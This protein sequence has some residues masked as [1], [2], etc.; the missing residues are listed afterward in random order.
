MK[1]LFLVCLTLLLCMSCM[2]VLAEETEC[3]QHTASCS[4]PTTCTVCGA[5][6]ITPD[7]VVHAANSEWLWYADADGH[8]QYWSCCNQKIDELS[9]HGAFCN[10]DPTICETCGATGLENVYI[11]HV[12]EQGYRNDGDT[13]IMAWFCCGETVGEAQTHF[14]SCSDDKAD[15]CKACGA[16]GIEMMITHPGDATADWQSD[17]DTHSLRYNC[18]GYAIIEGEG[19]VAYCTE[20]N[21]C[22]TCGAV[23]EGYEIIHSGNQEW[24]HDDTTHW[25]EW[26]CC[27]TISS[28]VGPHN[29]PCTA[30]NVCMWC[31]AENVEI[32]LTHSEQSDI[33]SDEN[34]HWYGC[35]DCAEPFGDKIAHYVI[36]ANTGDR[37]K[38]QECSAPV[39]PSTVSVQHVELSD[40]EWEYD[41]TAHWRQECVCGECMVYEDHYAS[42]LAPEAGCE[43]CGYTG[44]ISVG[45]EWGE[46]TYIDEQYCGTACTRCGE[47][48]LIEHASFS[49]LS[50][51][52]EFCGS[53]FNNTDPNHSWE[54]REYDETGCWNVCLECGEEVNK[55]NHW[56][57]CA[58]PNTCANCG[59]VSP[60]ATQYDHAWTEV[61]E[62]DNPDYHYKHCTTCGGE[63]GI[64]SHTVSCANPGVC[65]GCGATGI[66][67][68]EI[69][70]GNVTWEHNATKHWGVC[71]TC[72]G[73]Q[74]EGPHW[75][76]CSK[77][78]LCQDCGATG[79]TID[80][81]IL[82]HFDVDWNNYEHDAT[83][84]W[85]TC[86]TCN[87]KAFY[88]EHA[89]N[90][91]SAG[92]C[93]DCGY[94]GDFDVQHPALKAGW[95]S[96]ENNH[97]KICAVCND[98]VNK[99]AHEDENRDDKCDICKAQLVHKHYWG[100]PVIV[101]ATCT[102]DGSKTTTC[103]TCGEKTVETIASTGH[104]WGEP[105]IVDATCTADGSKTTTC[106]TCG[107]KTMET[108]A[109]TGHS[110]GEPVIVK[111]TCTADGSKTT[112]CDTCGEKAM[113]TIASTGHAWGEPVI[114]DATC[115]ADGSKTIACANCDEKAMET[116]ASTGHAW[117]EPVIVKATCTADGSKTTTCD[118]CG[119]KTMETI[120]STGHAWSEPVIVDATC[121]AD[122]S[123][124]ITCA[125]CGEKTVEVIKSTG[126]AWGEPV[127]VKATCT[128]DG[129]KTI[130]CATCDEETVE[131]IRSR[132]GHNW[133]ITENK[134]ATCT[135][136]G[137]I[138]KVCSVCNV[139]T[140]IVPAATGHAWGA[141]VTVP[142]T[143]TADGNTTTTCANCGEKIVENI[144]AKGHVWGEPVTIPATCTADGS[145]TTT[146]ATCGEKTVEVIASTGHAW[147]EPVTIPATC[148]AN[149]S[150]T[151]T[152]TTCGE[153]TVEVIASTGHAYGLVYTTQG[154]GTHAKTCSVCGAIQSA[155]CSLTTTNMGSM[156]CSACATCGYTVYTFNEVAEEKPAEP[157]KTETTQAAADAN[158]NASAEKVEESA[159][160]VTE[161]KAETVVKRVENVSFELVEPVVEETKENAADENVAAETVEPDDS[162][163]AVVEAETDETEPEAPADQSEV[164][165]VVHETKVEMK[166]ELPD[167]VTAEVKKVLAVSLLKEGNAIQPAATVKLS[168]PVVEEE[169]TGLKL[170]LMTDSGEL[171]EVE[172]EIVDGVIVFATDMVGV[173]LFVD[174]EA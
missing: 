3:T 122:G 26:S 120:A 85:Y 51:I 29:A 146:C 71:S 14:D 125:T 28:D 174:A 83:H 18:C 167:T 173:F 12:G 155:K 34:V 69:K 19:H 15:T 30:P 158:A 58:A 169:V 43:R 171:V 33:W 63:Y 165:L 42:C 2:A 115:T 60:T 137:R 46:T 161:A 68:D 135:A 56:Y 80:P 52:C 102:A 86:R 103:D 139:Y 131:V 37:T 7:M 116:I 119:E 118:T 105:V 172:Y 143:C 81:S 70:H 57:T 40:A 168:I 111:A 39:D 127:I 76:D 166:V 16:T 126:H 94:V 130:T 164:V 104:A 45:H 32:T 150:K 124:T 20:T 38:C 107:E 66:T 24:Q 59:Y 78:N 156:T 170:M 49:C 82:S 97:W 4:A 67:V 96:D 64:A 134:A 25:L 101:D 5:T 106:D 90:C 50:N 72:G 55:S 11:T 53:E 153:K 44:S 159:P 89:V 108:I 22:L 132:G 87:I 129:S 140:V 123:K 133:K 142:A 117:S 154:N 36:C 100:E 84:H 54:G 109:A 31:S 98:A 148:T 77:P 88:E 157:E 162:A 99:A 48:E 41:E 160:A 1:R 121:T 144:A 112:T 145:K 73:T 93:A 74:D 8:Y 151:T 138:K 6:G 95:E 163:E 61:Y 152:C 13:H 62:K 147:G 79:V 75:T 23:G 47:E 9:P 65:T 128:A 92:A 35:V 91:T 136:D 114:V 27:G 17:G 110:W 149:G 141:P 10:E 21:K 113:E